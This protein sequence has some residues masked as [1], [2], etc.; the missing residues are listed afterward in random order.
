M[1]AS[2]KDA[3]HLRTEGDRTLTLNRL[4]VRP[5]VL[6]PNMASRVGT[7]NSYM[8]TEATAKQLGFDL[9]RERVPGS[10]ADLSIPRRAQ[11][12]EERW[13]RLHRV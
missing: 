1:R 2:G 7:R 6:A 13:L 3:L 5:P 9:M 4:D 12:L 11:V 10:L 8:E